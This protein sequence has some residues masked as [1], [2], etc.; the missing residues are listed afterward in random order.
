MLT[1]AVWQEWFDL[2]SDWASCRRL[3]FAKTQQV[4]IGNALSNK[5]PINH[6]VLQAQ[7]LVHYCLF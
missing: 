5:C 4:Q 6:G 3:Y 7:Y 2:K 1:K